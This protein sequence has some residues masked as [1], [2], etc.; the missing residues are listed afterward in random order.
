MAWQNNC[1]AGNVEVALKIERFS[2]ANS[3][4]MKYIALGSFVNFDPEDQIDS[5][6]INPDAAAAEGALAVAAVDALDPGL[7]TPELFSSRGPIT[8]LFDKDGVR[9]PSPQ[10]RSK[11][12]L[13]AADGLSTTV[14]GFETFFGTSAAVPSAAGVAAVLRSSDPG[15]SADEIEQAMTD[16]ANAIDCIESALV[17]DPDCGA[18]FLLADKAFLSLDIT[19][20]DTIINSGPSGTIT[21]DEASFTFAGTPAAD[22][23]KVQCRIDSEPFADCT[24]PKTFS[25]LSDG[26]HTAEFRAENAIGGRDATPATRTFTVDSAVPVARISKL[27]VSGPGKVRKGGRATYRVRITNSGVGQATGVKLR[28]RGKGVSLKRSVGKIAAAETRAV[29]VKLKPK[30]AGKVKVSFKVTS[31]NAGGKTVSKRIKVRKRR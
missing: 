7:D 9:L 14:P 18:G 6:T 12:E 22:T 21:T 28:V 27:K 15:A 5:N 13:A 31:G 11:P 1:D 25:G 3:P 23:A 19:T 30:K 8:R 29:K 20:P 4:F 26:P 2:G 16:P 17:P 10:V 24:S